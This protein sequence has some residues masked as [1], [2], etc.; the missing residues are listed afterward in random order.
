MIYG[1]DS[2]VQLVLQAAEQLRRYGTAVP[3]GTVPPLTPLLIVAITSATGLSPDHA[4][5]VIMATAWAG[6][7][8]AVFAALRRFGAHVRLAALGAALFAVSPSRVLAIFDMHDAAQLCFGT[9]TVV[10]VLLWVDRTLARAPRVA[11]L[12][13]AAVAFALTIPWPLDGP[14]TLSVVELAAILSLPRWRAA[15]V[16]L[17]R[18]PAA[19]L[20]LG[21][22][23]VPGLWCLV[24]YPSLVAAPQAMPPGVPAWITDNSLNA[25]VYGP[26]SLET[27]AAANCRSIDR[28]LRSPGNENLSVRWLRALG[29]EYFISRDWPKFHSRLECVYEEAEWCIYAVPG[30]NPA[31]AVLVSRFAWRNLPRLR[32]PL[33]IDGLGA[34]E[35]W[36][37]R[38]EAAGL[39]RLD[40]GRV[41]IRCDVG[42]DDLILARL[43]LRHGWRAYLETRG[44]SGSES[45]AEEIKIEADPLGFMVLDPPLT[46]P[47]LITLEYRPDFSER[48]GHR[49]TPSQPFLEGPFPRIY[50]GGI[51]DARTFALPPFRPGAVLSV[52]G[53]HFV[54]GDTQVFFGSMP[55][56]VLYV[57]PQQINVRLP[58]ETPPGDVAVTVEA[59]GRL[60]GSRQIEVVE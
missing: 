35:A 54:A 43:P 8:A 55:G 34:Y 7:A 19:A 17:T 42:P 26:P 41:R 36:A 58:A 14:G 9:L 47:L 31:E 49:P 18:P 52:F 16:R 30:I 5:A 37:S 11:A 32:G 12:G 28:V 45:P 60:S 25:R 50:R 29:I 27:Q 39:D 13:S 51:G 53:E 23:S 38:P 2:T 48:L 20:V 3:Y 56:E 10:L 21:V 44:A 4:Y 1:P 6:G 59:A 22:F 24:V 33:D 15:A 40:D 57:V 46:G